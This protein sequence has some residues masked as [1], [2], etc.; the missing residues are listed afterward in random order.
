MIGEAMLRPSYRRVSHARLLLV[1]SAAALA[2]C[3]GPREVT[4]GSGEV[5]VSEGEVGFPAIVSAGSF[6]GS[7]SEMSGYHLIVWDEGRAAG[8][9]LF[10]T[11]VSDL[12]VLEALESLG[13]VPGDALTTESW[14]RRKD[15]EDP[16][17]GRVIEGPPVDILVRVP[18]RSEPLVPADYLID[19][20][21]R[22]VRMRFGGHRANR[23]EWHSGCVA[24]LFSCPGSK[25][26]NAAY[27]IRDFVDGTTR[28]EVRSGVLPPD[29]T[30]VEIVLR[31]TDP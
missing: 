26:G 10:R 29:G 9:A 8:E 4:A 7:S 24:C 22:G 14:N 21:G 27:T 23:E 19:P 20:G 30:R 25:V 1:V 15:P 28:F 5:R 13:A 31:L 11:P 18:G 16:E 2:A 17:P 12:A 3:S 6:S